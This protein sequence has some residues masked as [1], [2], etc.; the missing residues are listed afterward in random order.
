MM[1]KAGAL[2]RASRGASAAD[3]LGGES[4]ISALVETA[5]SGE[6]PPSIAPAQGQCAAAAVA[7]T[8]TGT[9]G[10]E[11]ARGDGAPTHRQHNDSARGGPPP[12]M[13]DGLLALPTLGHRG[14]GCEEPGISDSPEVAVSGSGENSGS[15]GFGPSTIDPP[16][17]I[18][19]LDFAA[20]EVH[21]L[22]TA[23]ANG[24][25]D[26]EATTQLGA[27]PSTEKLIDHAIKLSRLGCTLPTST[28]ASSTAVPAAT[29]T[30]V[31]AAT[32]SSAPAT[33]ELQTLIDALDALRHQQTMQ[34][35]AAGAP[36]FASG[37]AL[38]AVLFQPTTTG[39]MLE[40]AASPRRRRCTSPGRLRGRLPQPCRRR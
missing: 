32:S 4:E 35:Q 9:S 11:D 1:K 39:Q 5:P 2:R 23:R 26:L 6:T 13:G 22:A 40:L 27:M 17:T 7:G 31:P 28:S 19:Q 29:S 14:P 34:I 21:V 30:A 20:I 18:D 24:L 3:P 25:P 33:T 8:G 16:S 12:A 10:A 36:A 37:Q 15:A 38:A